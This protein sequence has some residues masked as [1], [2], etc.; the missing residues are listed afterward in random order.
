VT[1]QRERAGAHEYLRR[2]NALAGVGGGHPLLQDLDLIELVLQLPPEL[3]FDPMLDRP[4][5]RTAIPAVPDVIRTRSDKAYFTPL[6][7]EAVDVHDAAEIRRL[8]HAEDAAIRAYTQ[9][10]LV[11]EHLLDAAPAQRGEDRAWALWRL[12]VAELWLRR[13]AG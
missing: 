9:P 10:E 3:A 5:L 7:L 1:E 4:L 6:F 11:R 13:L 8:V 2:R 12:A